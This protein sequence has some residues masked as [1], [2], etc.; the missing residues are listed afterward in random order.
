MMYV[1]YYPNRKVKTIAHYQNGVLH[2]DVKPA[3]SFYRND[4]NNT[5]KKECFY[6]KG[7]PSTIQEGKCVKW[8]YL[9]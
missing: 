3:L 5:I 1:T 2:H 7:K 4:T 8:Y 6:Y 9:I